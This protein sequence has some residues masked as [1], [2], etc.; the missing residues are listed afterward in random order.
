MNPK[1][2]IMKWSPQIRPT[3]RGNGSLSRIDKCFCLFDTTVIMAIHVL[4]ITRKHISAGV[5]TI[6]S[7]SDLGNS[8]Y[9]LPQVG[10]H[11]NLDEMQT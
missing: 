11:F 2:Q 10:K 1:V 7:R 8:H 6:S 9:T 5:T 4:I 3:N